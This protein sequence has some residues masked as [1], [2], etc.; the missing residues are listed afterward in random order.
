MRKTCFG[1]GKDLFVLIFVKYGHFPDFLYCSR[2]V[3]FIF[4]IIQSGVML[5][6]PGNG[7]NDVSFSPGVS[8][9]SFTSTPGADSSTQ[10]LSDSW[11]FCSYIGGGGD[12]GSAFTSAV[13]NPNKAIVTVDAKTSE[14]G[15]CGGLVLSCS[16][17]SHLNSKCLPICCSP[18]LYSWPSLHS[19]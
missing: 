18:Q 17:Q 16:C 2:Y 1:V 15:S 19:S 5:L 14:V 3:V 7:M 13:R 10:G 4:E 8:H 6:L 11:S 12:M 9:G